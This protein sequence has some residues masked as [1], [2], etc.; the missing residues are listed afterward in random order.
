MRKRSA[1]ATVVPSTTAAAA[2]HADAPSKRIKHLRSKTDPT[3]QDP[4]PPWLHEAAAQFVSN[5]PA[6]K[7]TGGFYSWGT[8]LD[9]LRQLHL[10]THSATHPAPAPWRALIDACKQSG[11]VRGTAALYRAKIDLVTVIINFVFRRGEAQRLTHKGETPAAERDVMRRVRAVVT[12][13]RRHEAVALTLIRFLDLAFVF[14]AYRDARLSEAA[15]KGSSAAEVRS[16]VESELLFLDL[17]PTAKDIRHVT[18]EMENHMWTCR[19]LPW[20]EQVPGVRDEMVIEARDAARSFCVGLPFPHVRVGAGVRGLSRDHLAGAG[21]MDQWLV[22]LLDL[23]LSRRWAGLAAVYLRAVEDERGEEDMLLEE[24]SRRVLQTMLEPLTEVRDGLDPAH[25][26]LIDAAPGIIVTQ[27]V[28]ISGR[29]TFRQLLELYIHL[30]MFGRYL[31]S[32]FHHCALPS[33]DEIHSGVV[34]FEEIRRRAFEVRAV[35]DSD[36]LDTLMRWCLSTQEYHSPDSPALKSCVAYQQAAIR[37]ALGSAM[38]RFKANPGAPFPESDVAESDP[39]TYAAVV[40][41]W[42]P[43]LAA[44]IID[45]AVRIGKPTRSRFM[46][47]HGEGI[48]LYTYRRLV[49]CSAT[50]ERFLGDSQAAARLMKRFYAVWEVCEQDKGVGGFDRRGVIHLQAAADKGN[51]EAYSAYGMLLCSPEWE[52][53]REQCG[54]ARDVESGIVLICKAVAVCDTGAARD[55]IHLLV[56]NPSPHNTDG[57]HIP[58]PLVDYAVRCLREAARE[59]P[60]LRLFLG[61]LYS[62]G[63]TGI[64]IDYNASA[65]AYQCVLESVSAGP[66]YQA[67]AANNLGVLRVF[68]PSSVNGGASRRGEA[69]DYIKI[70]AA[71]SDARAESNLAALLCLEGRDSY[72]QL[73]MAKQ[74]YWNCL[75]TRGSGS[76]LTVLQFNRD[77]MQ[78]TVFDVIVAE[79]KQR[80]FCNDLSWEGMPLEQYGTILSAETRAYSPRIAPIENLGKT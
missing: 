24:T 27:S 69:L 59:E 70:A 80:S 28:R 71:A 62:Q 10:W 13:Q 21:S 14:S 5:T 40:A 34:L 63:A 26:K 58:Q 7:W 47:G 79:Q 11:Q 35:T 74:T 75:E 12:R 61:Y 57:W 6:L 38:L 53:H 78:V 52:E 8:W 3:R 25:S 1:T 67:H 76:P 60:A 73:E 77:P 19:W 65:V 46:S 51:F 15:R 31:H 29:F 49:V 30:S 45:A 42:D 18:V 32:N 68:N 9:D 4:A 72:P 37:A 50:R 48:D 55:L 43:P 39:L 54:L 23:R 56:S 44:K 17:K 33:I 22:S 36:K 66:R 41:E 64:P 16:Q 2:E 20:Y